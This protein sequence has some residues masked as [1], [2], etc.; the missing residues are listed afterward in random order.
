MAVLNY[1]IQGENSGLL[2]AIKQAIAA[3]S[4]TQSVVDKL[5]KTSLGGIS[6]GFNTATESANNF[7]NAAKKGTQAFTDQ[8]I[9]NALSRL[10][11][12]LAVTNGNFQLFGGSVKNSQQALSAYQQALNSLLSN[13]IAPTD[14]RIIGFK[15]HIDEL[16]SSIDKQ[17]S[18]SGGGLG[19]SIASGITGGIATLASSY[20]GLYAAVSGVKKVIQSNA[21]ISDSLADIRRTAGLTQPEVESLFSS[22]KKIDTRTSLKG[23]A[24]IAI[25]GGQLGIAKD[26]LAGFTKAVDELSV[27]LGGELKG[28]PEEVAQSLGIL[29]KVFGISAQNGGDVERSFNKIGSVIL[30]LGQSGL[31]TGDF[32]TDFAKRV[33]GVAAQAK[34]DLP[35]LLSYGAVLQ[36]QGVSAEVAGTSFKKLLGSLATKREAFL[37]IA[38]IADSTLT[39]KSFTDII[40]NDTQKALSL[41]FTGLAQGG[42]TTTAF[43]DLLKSVG[44][45]AARSGQAIT[46]LALHQAD[47]TKHISESNDQYKDGTLAAEQFKVKNDT[48]GASVDKLGKSFIS[49]TTTGNISAFFKSIVDGLTGTLNG[50]STLVNSASWGE[51]FNRLSHPFGQDSK[52]AIDL[53]YSIPKA[54]KES[55]SVAVDFNKTNNPLGSSNDD[56][57]ELL[58]DKSAAQLKA[59]IDKYKAAADQAVGALNDYK[60]GIAK[61]LISDGGEFSV[62]DATKNFHNLQNIL[63]IVTHAYVQVRDK[64]TNAKTSIVKDSG[65]IA[66]AELKTVRAINARILQLKNDSLSNPGNADAD[67]ARIDALRERLAQFATGSKSAIGNSFLAI[68]Q[69]LDNILLRSDALGN[70][71]GLTGYSLNVEKILDNYKKLNSEV[72]QNLA[73]AKK[74]YDNGNLTKPQLKA[75]Q[76]KS[77]V[78]KDAIGDSSQKQLDAAKIDNAEKVANE[79]TRINNEFGIKAEQ[80]RQ[81][82]IDQVKAIAS[83][84]IAAQESKS[85]TIEQINARYDA[86]IIAANGNQQKI[87]AAGELKQVEIEQAKGASDTIVA[88]KAGELTAIAAIND[89]YLQME[90][91]LYDKIAAINQQATDDQNDAANSETARINKTFSERIIAV[92]SYFEKLKA[93]SKTGDPTKDAAALASLNSKQKGIVNNLT[94]DQNQQIQIAISKPLIDG[95][96]QAAANFYTTLTQINQQTDQ[97]FKTIF[98]DL[99]K[100]L[101]TS[102]N[103]VFLNIVE[104]GLQTALQ[105][106]IK[107]GTSTLF[108]NNGGLTGLG[109]GIVGA[110]LAGGVISG[111]TPQTS[112]GGQAIGGALS[113]AAAGAAIGSIVPGIGTA[114]GA[115][116]GA[117]IGGISGLISAAK[118]RK[119]IEEQQLSEQQQQT[120]LLKASLAYTSQIIGRDTA[121]GIVTGVSVGAF[122]QLIAT[123]SGKDLQFVLDRNANGR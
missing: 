94:T 112:S 7:S 110:G 108:N 38:Q 47:L 68:S 78:T 53:Q 20:L 24:D 43:S 82:E 88:I 15:G 123:V 54:I 39:L 114:I 11:A 63:D 10:D 99:T 29:D 81:K 61:G 92:N 52:T 36:E 32:L 19:S 3:I 102:L 62:A 49:L 115:V 96:D 35:T 109:A 51:F 89:K 14:S 97:S 59:M 120:A 9:S 12:K 121:N 74:A 73:K 67:I 1:S 26:Q 113:G 30:G 55:K 13:G 34:L 46:A 33:G 40:N 77:T 103:S 79:I 80:S 105:N 69:A 87:D 101:S 65:E 66:D 83:K 8:S 122:G 45:D 118:A 117:I 50:F 60:K 16:T 27:S 104:K 91:D 42:S 58:A 22:L 76:D 75:I 84:E 31:A 18:A 107:N 98:A 25:I 106:A 41:F 119:V 85:E 21:E 100:Q 17:K 64:S 6:G 90:Q 111:A 71:S 23:L 93:I 57:T 86:A 95:I 44:L 56:V 70:S 28:G 72:D 4:G 5:N 116:G 37:P 2:A 48:L